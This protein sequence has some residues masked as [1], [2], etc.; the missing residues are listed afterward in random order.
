MTEIHVV[1][2][3]IR[4]GERIL[5]AQ[6]SQ[7]MNE[8]LKWEYAGG[9]VEAGETHQEALKREVYEELGIRVVVKGLIAVGYSEVNGKRIILHVYE[10]EIIEGIPEAREHLQIKW[11]YFNEIPGLDWA[12]ADIP[13]CNELVKRYG[14]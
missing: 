9:K 11:V 8:A 3:A 5:A 7:I 6:R 14:A 10:A 1:G 12:K 4:D 13:A 2:A